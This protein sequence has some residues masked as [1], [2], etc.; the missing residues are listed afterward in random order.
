MFSSCP[1]PPAFFWVVSLGNIVTATCT[2]H[3][4]IALLS[5]L[6]SSLWLDT[7]TVTT[8]S[9][10]R[11]ARKPRT[12]ES[13]WLFC[14]PLFLHCCLVCHQL[15]LSVSLSVSLSL[16]V[17]LS[18]SLITLSVCLSL[19]SL[20]LYVS[21]SH[22]F[23]SLSLSSLYLYPSLSLSVSLLSLILSLS[24]SLSLSLITLLK[25]SF[26]QSLVLRFLCLSIVSRCMYLFLSLSLW[27]YVCVCVS[28]SICLSLS[29][30]L[31]CLIWCLLSCEHCNVSSIIHHLLFVCSKCVSA[32]YFG[33]FLYICMCQHMHVCV[34]AC[35][36]CA[37]MC[38]C[39]YCMCVRVCIRVCVREIVTETVIAFP[40]V[41]QLSL[42][43]SCSTEGVPLCI[44]LFIVSP[45]AFFLLSLL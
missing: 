17:C 13:T 8:H 22:H 24:L 10:P 37:S 21:L 11:P 38:V 19:S 34:C 44:S 29:L 31:C 43:L 35:N 41:P 20:Y 45:L 39:V 5:A 3:L 36:M 2:L 25:C 15:L 9:S 40:Q 6:T 12:S 30:C 28:L 26:F 16:S 4:R 33:V 1:I 42:I 23:L 27:L 18:L 32:N 7:P 14:L